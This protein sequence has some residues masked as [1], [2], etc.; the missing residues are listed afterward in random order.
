[1]WRDQAHP[2]LFAP[3]WVGQRYIFLIII[4]EIVSE[5]D[6]AITRQLEIIV[7]RTFPRHELRRVTYM[8]PINFHQ[9]LL[10][11][12]AVYRQ[13]PYLNFFF[14]LHPSYGSSI[15]H[16]G[17]GFMVKH[18]VIFVFGNFK[19]F[20][21]ICHYVLNHVSDTQKRL[22]VVHCFHCTHP[23]ILAKTRLVQFYRLP[24]LFTCWCIFVKTD[25]RFLTPIG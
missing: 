4:W 12:E 7:Q 14:L 22:H 23:I 11:A 6:M 17:Q 24:K 19:K 21:G 18:P 5:N 15:S 1:M 25:Q 9:V 10:L 8:A 2:T 20:R 16:Q 3:L 13:Q